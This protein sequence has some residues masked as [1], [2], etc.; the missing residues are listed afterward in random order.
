MLNHFLKQLC[1][2]ITPSSISKAKSVYQETHVSVTYNSFQ[3]KHR[4]ILSH[5][6]KQSRSRYFKYGVIIPSNHDHDTSNTESLSQAI[7]I[8]ILQILSH[9]P[10]QSRSRYFKYGV[11]IPSNHDHDTS[12]FESLSQAIT[13]TIL[14]ILSHYPK[15]SRSR[16]FKY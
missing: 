15:R 9:Y 14:Q 6:P 11:I 16:C 13:I 1:S 7:T 3:V 12:N 5:Y 10:K 8:T 4:L 2:C